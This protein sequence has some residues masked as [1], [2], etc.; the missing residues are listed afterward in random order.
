MHKKRTRLHSATV[1]TQEMVSDIKHRL[2]YRRLPWKQSASGAFQE[3]IC[4]FFFSQIVKYPSRRLVTIDNR[5]Y[6]RIV[7]PLAVLDTVDKQKSHGHL[8][9]LLFFHLQRVKLRITTICDS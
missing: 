1:Q 7:T 3:A 5:S 9:F 8:R 6:P 2:S 4:L